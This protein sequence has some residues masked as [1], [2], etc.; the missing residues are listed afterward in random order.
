MSNASRITSSTVSSADTSTSLSRDDALD[1]LLAAANAFASDC[2]VAKACVQQAAELL[3]VSL[4]RERHPR[5]GSYS[6]GGLAPWQ[7]KRVAA[8]IESNIGA[9]FRTADL[10]HLV[11]FSVSHFFRAFKV[12]FGQSPLTYV[13]VRRMRRAQVI[14][15]NTRQPLAQVALDCGMSDQA[16]FSRVFRQVVGTCPSLWRRQFQSESALQTAADLV[17]AAA[18]PPAQQ[19]SQSHAFGIADLGGDLVDAG[20]TGFEKVHRALYPQVLE[21]GKRRLA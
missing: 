16:H 13:K 19:R 14:M 5:V 2:D 18:E 3:R 20:V 17:H 1:R 12:S 4:E 21:K 7:A 11:Q 6:R 8:Y 9:R 15:L 10:A